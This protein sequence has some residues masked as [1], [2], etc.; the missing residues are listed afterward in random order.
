MSDVH[1]FWP[2]SWDQLV[3]TP[4]R[5]TYHT[6]NRYFAARVRQIAGL[7]VSA[8]PQERLG[9]VR[10][11]APYLRDWITDT[12]TL[13]QA[14]DHLARRGGQAPGPD[15][16]RYHDLNDRETWQ[17]MRSIRASLRSGKS[18]PG[19]G[20]S[21]RS[22]RLGEHPPADPSE[23]HRPGRPACHRRDPPTAPRPVVRR[24]FVRVPSRPRCSPGP[25]VCGRP[26]RDR[27]GC[28]GHRG[29]RH[30]LPAGAHPRLL[31]VV[32]HYLPDDGLIDLIGQVLSRSQ[33]PGLR[34]GGPLS[35]L[36]LNLYL[37]HVLD[38]WWRTRHPGVVLLRYADDLLL[39]CRSEKELRAALADLTRRL[40]DVGMPLKSVP[41]TEAVRD[42]SSAKPARWLGFNI[43]GGKGRLRIRLHRATWDRLR[44]LLA[45]AHKAPNAPPRRRGGD[46]GLGGRGRAGVRGSPFRPGVP[47][48]GRA[49]RGG[50]IRGDPGPGG[51]E[52]VVAGRLRPLVPRPE[53]GGRT[54]TTRCRDCRVRTDRRLSREWR[55]MNK[56]CAMRDDEGNL[57]KIPPPRQHRTHA[58]SE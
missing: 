5:L 51:C 9:R 44:R 12:R 40:R 29:H 2:T 8:K 37:H 23:H 25:G 6:D 52:E 28:V 46:P 35:P 54:A 50:R 15:G 53:A 45:L 38:V 1:R 27:P 3:A 16:S 24:A 33:L 48:V 18:R 57:P 14:R 13:R 21:C 47:P 22:R 31:D 11:L 20:G 58:A 49:G 32:R 30:R 43:V 17:W 36:L 39:L 7:I 19:P 26:V 10:S 55:R 41:E 34:Q 4:R 42:L 56:G